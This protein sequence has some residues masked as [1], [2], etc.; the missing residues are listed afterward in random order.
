MAMKPAQCPTPEFLNEFFDGRLSSRRALA[1]RRHLA[2]CAHCRAQVDRLERLHRLLLSSSPPPAPSVLP[3]RIAA[4]LPGL[5][6]LPVLSCRRARQLI[7]ERLDRSLAPD[8]AE[9]LQAHLFNCASCL[10]Y[11]Q[12]MRRMVRLLHR[13]LAPASSGLARRI[14]TAVAA[15]EPQ[16]RRRVEPR[17]VPVGAALALCVLAVL[18]FTVRP[19][20]LPP[21]PAAT[22][23]APLEIAAPPA[24]ASPVAEPGAETTPPPAPVIA[25]ASTA[26]TAPASSRPARPSRTSRRLAMVPPAETRPQLVSPV[27]TAPSR[28]VVASSA[29][30]APRP[31]PVLVLPP[32]R[33]V[34]EPPAVARPAPL[35]T[36]PTRVPS[37]PT[38]PPPPTPAPSAPPARV[39]AAPPP[40][41]TPAPAAARTPAASAPRSLV[42]HEPAGQTRTLHWVPAQPKSVVVFERPQGQDQVL[43]EAGRA[44]QSYER[45]LKRSQTRSFPLGP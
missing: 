1:V 45:S 27:S 44:L 16:P 7:G 35:P 32:A 24:P 17:W 26:P 36:V 15:L 41:S 8:E 19:G 42:T 10:R 31:A 6:T 18:A 39:A 29:P 43:A 22:S 30:S 25:R 14:Q 23:P 20:P 38:A 40:P 21:S 33:S 5:Q 37:A 2:E 4:R 34:P 13:P 9:Q 11:A 3:E 12:E 28:P